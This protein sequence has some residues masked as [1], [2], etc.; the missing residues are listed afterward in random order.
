MLHSDVTILFWLLVT[1]VF[2]DTDIDECLRDDVCNYN[3]KCVNTNGGFMCLCNEGYQGVT[4]IGQVALL[5]ASCAAEDIGLRVGLFFV[6]LV[7]G[8]CMSCYLYL[9]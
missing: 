9:K 3:G 4:C 6:G 1:G 7:P 8:L 2:C 5:R